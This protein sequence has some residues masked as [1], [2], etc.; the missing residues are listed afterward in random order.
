MKAPIVIAPVLI[1]LMLT[2]PASACHRFSFW[3]FNYPQ[4]RCP[5]AGQKIG[6]SALPTPSAPDI[7][8]PDLSQITWGD[9]GDERLRA[10]ALLRDRLSR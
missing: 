2:S 6:A 7:P 3:A 10:V 8:L 9:V 5:L 1:L 4:P